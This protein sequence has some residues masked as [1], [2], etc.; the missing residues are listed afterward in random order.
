MAWRAVV[1]RIGE[2]RAGRLV[3][4]RGPL[5]RGQHRGSGRLPIGHRGGSGSGGGGERL[6]RQDRQVGRVARCKPPPRHVIQA[7]LPTVD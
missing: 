6:S 7:G 2:R 4:E 1:A 3:A 5:S